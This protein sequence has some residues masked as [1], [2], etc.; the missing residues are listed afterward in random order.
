MDPVTSRPVSVAVDVGV[1][2]AVA[3]VPGVAVGF[4]GEDG[5]GVFEHA[6]MITHRTA[7]RNTSAA[8]VSL[9]LT[10]NFFILDLLKKIGNKYHH[11]GGV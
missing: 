1:I 4:D 5:D 6:W 2:V 3:M 10:G 7:A 9:D 8:A 11:L